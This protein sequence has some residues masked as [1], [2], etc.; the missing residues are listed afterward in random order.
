MSIPVQ[1]YKRN[2]ILEDVIHAMKAF[3]RYF[4][5]HLQLHRH[6]RGC[7]D[8]SMLL[9]VRSIRLYLNFNLWDLNF[10][11]LQFLK[12][13]DELSAALKKTKAAMDKGAKL[14]VSPRQDS[15]GYPYYWVE[16]IDSHKTEGIKLLASEEITAFLFQYMTLGKAIEVIAIPEKAEEMRKE[17]TDRSSSFK[18]FICC[19]YYGYFSTSYL[20]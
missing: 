6:G 2:K 1:R 8:N 19:F 4:S 5:Y 15:N 11:L 3:I 20:L 16:I 7:K 17:Y 14:T 18:L 9:T 13:A 12:N 10:S